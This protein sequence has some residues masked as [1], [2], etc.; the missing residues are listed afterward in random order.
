METSQGLIEFLER[1][2]V[3]AT[4]DS[5]TD[6]AIARQFLPEKFRGN[7]E[8]LGRCSRESNSSVCDFCRANYL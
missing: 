7:D 1:K 4:G 2:G 5:Y 3:K 6:I 8:R